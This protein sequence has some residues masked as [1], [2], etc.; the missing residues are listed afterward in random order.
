MTIK[1][2]STGGT[3]S[4]PR[5]YVSPKPGVTEV[6]PTEPV[7]VATLEPYVSPTPVTF[8]FP[9]PEPMVGEGEAEPSTAF[10][11]PTNWIIA[12]GGIGLLLIIIIA[13]LIRAITKKDNP[14]PIIINE[15]TDQ[16]TAPP[17]QY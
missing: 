13:M 4:T 12:L 14:P 6:V 17:E 7:P 9:T 10:G 5:P 8:D 11:I 15:P 3:V 2:S 16:P 1:K